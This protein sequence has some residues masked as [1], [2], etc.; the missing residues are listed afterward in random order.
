MQKGLIWYFRSWC[1]SL[2]FSPVV[3]RQLH[4]CLEPKKSR[5][6]FYW[7]MLQGSKQ[8]WILFYC[9]LIGW[10]FERQF[11]SLDLMFSSIKRGVWNIS[12]KSYWRNKH[13]NILRNL[14]S[15]NWHHLH[16]IPTF[17]KR[18]KNVAFKVIWIESQCFLHTSRFST[19][20]FFTLTEVISLDFW[21]FSR[22][23]KTLS[24]LFTNNSVRFFVFYITSTF[25]T[26]I[27][28]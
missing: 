3:L 14:K 11:S 25:F 28:S 18:Q 9:L 26:I 7:E 22:M 2:H 19:I 13:L 21:F 24:H 17:I 5:F 20:L 16:I 27:F 23:D 4:I 10:P 8:E 6:K 1:C 15:E 12:F